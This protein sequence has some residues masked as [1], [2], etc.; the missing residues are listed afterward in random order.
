M[1]IHFTEI[2]KMNYLQER[3]Y[4]ILEEVHNSPL[5]KYQAQKNIVWIAE[6][7]GYKAT[8]ETAFYRELKKQILKLK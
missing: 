2:E 7:N 4:K 3:G 5:T 8:L 1:Q 6:K